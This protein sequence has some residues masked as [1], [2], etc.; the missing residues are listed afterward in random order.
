MKK[1][2]IIGIFIILIILVILIAVNLIRNYSI[3]KEIQES[4]Q[5]FLADLNNYSFTE[6]IP[7]GSENVNLVT[8]EV[9]M[10][11]NIYLE[12]IYFDDTLHLT[13]WFDKNTGETISVDEEGNLSSTDINSDFVSTYEFAIL[14]SYSE[15]NYFSKIMMSHIISPILL[16][17]NCYVINHNNYEIKINKDT[18]LIEECCDENGKVIY[19]YE[20]E[21][22]TVTDDMVAKPN[23]LD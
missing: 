10:K 4:N 16:E 6:K 3:L 9:L 22:N 13:V 20:L 8:E 14:D 18:K 2:V 21:K 23:P 19:Q 7:F 17:D 12:K 15:E 5:G 1:K 11:D